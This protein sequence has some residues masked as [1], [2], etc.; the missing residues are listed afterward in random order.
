MSKVVRSLLIYT[1]I[2]LCLGEAGAQNIVRIELVFMESSTL[3]LDVVRGSMH[4]ICKLV[5]WR[6]ARLGVVDIRLFERM[7]ARFNVGQLRDR[8]D[9]S[10][11]QY[12]SWNPDSFSL[13]CNY[14][15]EFRFS[16]IY[17]PEVYSRLSHSMKVFRTVGAVLGQQREVSNVRC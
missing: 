11:L 10:D 9:V 8:Y 2:L 14:R 7:V 3:C 13:P 4:G 16:Q 17:S 15:K 1:T 6:K 12:K 5:Q